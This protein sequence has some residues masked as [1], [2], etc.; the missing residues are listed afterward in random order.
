[1][2]K[3][4]V[5]INTLNEEE[6]LPHAI[7][8]VKGFAD[9]IVVVDMHSDD[10]TP[11][12]AKNLGAKVFEHERVGYVEPARNFAISKA[13]GDW[14]LILD[15]DEEI[16]LSLSK[17]LRKIVENPDAD[18]YRLPRKNIIFGKWMEHTGWWPDYNIRFFKKGYVSWNEIIHSV[19][20]TQGKGFDLEAK[21]E[22]ALL[23]HSYNSIE[24]FVERLNRYTTHQVRSLVRGGYKFNWEDLIIKPFDEFFKRYFQ[25][26]GYKDGLHGFAL[27]LFQS[28]S[29]LVLYLKAWQWEKFIDQKV[30]S[31]DVTNEIKKKLNELNYWKAD[32]LVRESGSMI[33]RVKRKFKLP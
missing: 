9:E 6:N 19:P 11:D 30:N 16:S 24:Q 27:S 32:V 13:T 28:F 20:T 12:I 33:E 15:A 2:G 25:G 14:I 8:S 22:N 7:A 31:S 4:S 17:S 5:I 29:E 26:Q 3:I 1:V 21:E 18:Y 23:H 10:K